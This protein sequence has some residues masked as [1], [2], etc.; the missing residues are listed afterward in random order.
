MRQLH[1]D[2]N[3]PE[4]LRYLLLRKQELENLFGKFSDLRELTKAVL[5][6]KIFQ[7]HHSCQIIVQTKGLARGEVYRYER[8]NLAE[9]YPI[10]SKDFGELFLAIKKS[11]YKLFHHEQ[12]KLFAQLRGTFLAKELN[13]RKHHVVLMISRHDFLPPTAHEQAFFG[14]MALLLG[15]VM[16]NLLAVQ[17]RHTRQQMAMAVLEIFPAPLTIKAGPHLTFTNAAGRQ[18]SPSPSANYF[19]QQSPTQ[20]LKIGLDHQQDLAPDIYHFQRIQLLG[21]LLDTLHHELCNPLFG[22]KLWAEIMA[23]ERD[24]L[25]QDNQEF[26]QEIS[27]H[28]LRCQNIIEN[29]S[30]LY[31]D[32]QQASWIDLQ[33][34]LPEIML[35]IKSAGRQI[36]KEII[37]TPATKD[38]LWFKTNPTWLTQILFNLLINST[39]ALQ[40]TA[41][42]NPQ[43]ILQVFHQD[44]AKMV[45]ATQDNGKGIPPE[46]LPQIFLPFFTTKQNGTGLGLAICK[47]LT[48]RLHGQI[49]YT[50]SPGPGMTFLVT[51]PRPAGAPLTPLQEHHE[52][53]KNSAD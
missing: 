35:L 46:I 40:E 48:Q 26:L 21:E 10:T 47:N 22:I 28:A 42:E 20:T 4:N 49:S 51:L 11:K 34:L 24:T 15:P 39:Q 41:T 36:K 12:F 6:L 13:L 8:P 52:P 19:L 1:H 53:E 33:V 29:F 44:P 27:R 31:N 14:H 3:L 25:G 37:F 5:N 45:F 2:A 23:Q 43:I 7:G 30:V 50:T 38:P 18:L 17:R 16:E 32:T 9:H